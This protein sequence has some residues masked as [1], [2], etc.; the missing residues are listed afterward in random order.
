[1]ASVRGVL[2]LPLPVMTMCMFFVT[3]NEY[4]YLL[5]LPVMT[6]CMFFVTGNEYVYVLRYR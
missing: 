1:M 5:P 4:V 6:M 3:G 2:L